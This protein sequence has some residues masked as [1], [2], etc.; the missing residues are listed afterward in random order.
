MDKTLKQKQGIS[1]RKFLKNAGG[2][3]LFIGTSG[4]LSQ[5]VAC[6]NE[7][8]V[9]AILQKQQLTAWIEMDTD[10]NMIIYNPA[11]EMGQGSMTSLPVIFAE[12]MDADWS[13]VTVNSHR[14]YQKFMV[15]KVGVPTERSCFRQGAGSLRVIIICLEKQELKPVIYSCWLRLKSGNFP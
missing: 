6:S 7:K 12:E 11:A 15:P 1:R 3:T 9:K 14:K 8:K 4:L 5:V 13:K 2:V 10:G